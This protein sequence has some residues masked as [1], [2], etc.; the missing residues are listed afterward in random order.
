MKTLR[1]IISII[2]A[3]GT[4]AVFNESDSFTPNFFG[5]ICFA[6]LVA[7]DAWEQLKDRF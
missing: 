7:A 1:I 3:I 5:L 2:L 6:L 4:F